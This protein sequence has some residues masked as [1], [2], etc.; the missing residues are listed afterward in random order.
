MRL[1]FPVWENRISP[2]LDTAT[3]LL[4]VDVEDHGELSRSE[5]LLDERDV[6]R[7]CRKIRSL[8][9]NGLI[10][11]AVTRRLSD[12]LQDSGIHVIP[13]VSGHPDEVVD[14]CL[15]G[16]LADSKFLMPGWN[17]NGLEERIK[18]L[19]LKAREKKKPGSPGSNRKRDPW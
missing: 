11:G 12:M 8:G 17:V 7:K 9:V 10:C 3:R 13:G 4:I 14:A 1:A 15:E 18:G 6:S 19:N 5:I 2:V 16:R